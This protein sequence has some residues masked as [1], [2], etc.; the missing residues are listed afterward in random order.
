MT[1]PTSRETKLI[2]PYQYHAVSHQ[3][4]KKDGVNERKEANILCNRLSV[5]QES[6][7]AR[8][9][10]LSALIIGIALH[11]FPKLTF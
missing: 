1:Y 2:A 6:E 3:T 4:R 9:S 10:E 5:T 11:D 8:I 7:R